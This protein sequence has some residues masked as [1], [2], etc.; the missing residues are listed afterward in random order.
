MCNRAKQPPTTE[1]SQKTLAGLPYT[2]NYQSD[3]GTY[4]FET[5]NGV[6]YACKFGNVMS[7]LPPLLGIYD[8][9]VRDFLFYPYYP[10]L[11]A[12]KIRDERIGATILDLLDNY[13]F[14]NPERVLVYTCDPSSGRFGE[15]RQKVFSAW[16]ENVQHI[17]DRY[18]IEVQKEQSGEVVHGGIIVRKNFPYQEILQSQLIDK[19]GEIAF[20][21][22]G[23]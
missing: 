8:L 21:K 12:R 19:A 16:Y 17:F 23:R 20:E 13:F 11:K 10:N 5:D 7:M 15:G 14:V 22:F 1:K 18:E 6:E 2:I 3:I 4:N 9:E